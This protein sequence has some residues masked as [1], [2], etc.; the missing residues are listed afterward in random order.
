MRIVLDSNILV[1][2]AWKADG[3]A[4]LPLRAILDGSHRLVVRPVMLR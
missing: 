1:R 2:A 4:S 3:L